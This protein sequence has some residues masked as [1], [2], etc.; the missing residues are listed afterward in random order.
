MASIARPRVFLDVS[1]G[2]EPIGRLVIELFV[3]KA[4]KTCEKYRC[5][6]Q[7]L[8][9]LANI[10]LVSVPYVLDQTLL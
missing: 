9:F 6:T 1:V 3:D 4:P 5:Y 7:Q 2:T 10:F 8:D